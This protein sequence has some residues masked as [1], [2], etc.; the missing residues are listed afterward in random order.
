MARNE[1]SQRKTEKEIQL[2]T[3]NYQIK[4]RNHWKEREIAKEF[5]ILPASTL[6]LRT[7]FQHSK[8][9]SEYL[10]YCNASTE[11]REHSFQEFK[12]TF[13]FIKLKKTSKM[14]KWRPLVTMVVKVM[15]LLK[16]TILWKSSEIFKGSLE[17]EVF[18]K[19]LKLQ[20]LSQSLKKV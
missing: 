8:E 18:L 20:K 15:L 6:H 11:Q 9:I 1:R 16:S 7:R 2:P 17:K 14:R 5:N 12:R 4:S 10:P 19:K 13:F 3:K